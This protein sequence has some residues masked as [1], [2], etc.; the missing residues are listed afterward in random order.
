MNQTTLKLES[1]RLDLCSTFSNHIQAC[2]QADDNNFIYQHQ[3][4][5]A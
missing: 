5:L 1:V 2:L 4:Y 3:N